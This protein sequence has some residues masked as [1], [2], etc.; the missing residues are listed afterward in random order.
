MFLLFN[1]PAYEHSFYFR[2]ND[3]TWTLDNVFNSGSLC[4][5]N[6]AYRSYKIHY[7]EKTFKQEVLGL[8][9]LNLEEYISIAR[10]NSGFFSQ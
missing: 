1:S 2:L 8:Y 9:K 3:F 7:L 4:H 6:Y 5:R 10:V